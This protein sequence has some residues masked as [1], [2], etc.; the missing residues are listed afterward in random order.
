[1]KKAAL[2]TNTLM[3]TT[4]RIDEWEKGKAIRMRTLRVTVEHEAQL[5]AVLRI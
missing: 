2:T 1:M 5:G 4:M 3:P